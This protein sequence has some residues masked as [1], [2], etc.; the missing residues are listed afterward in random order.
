MRTPSNSTYLS[1]RETLANAHKEAHKKMVIA[2]LFAKTENWRQ[3]KRTPVGDWLNQSSPCKRR[4]SSGLKG[5][6]ELWEDPQDTLISEK[7]GTATASM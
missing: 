5:E 6:V 1:A 2:A 7:N 4:M 3:P